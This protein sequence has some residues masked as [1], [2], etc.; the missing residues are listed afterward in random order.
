MPA[1]DP[2]AHVVVA[3]SGALDETQ[4]QRLLEIAGRCPV[5]QTLTRGAEVTAELA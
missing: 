4:R 3:E 2:E 1:R 5:S